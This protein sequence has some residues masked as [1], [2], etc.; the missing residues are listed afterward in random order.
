MGI[1]PWVPM[2]KFTGLL[3]RC[4][5]FLWRP[6]HEVHLHLENEMGTKERVLFFPISLSIKSELLCSLLRGDFFRS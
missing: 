1:Y 5:P 2:S 4:G 6:G 3:M